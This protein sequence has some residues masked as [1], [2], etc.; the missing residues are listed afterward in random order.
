VAFSR[1][2]G[3]RFSTDA[4]VW[5]RT[6]D[7]LALGLSGETRLF[8][9]EQEDAPHIERVNVPAAVSA[10]AAGGKIDFLGDGMMQAVVSGNARTEDSGWLTDFR[11][12]KT[13]FTKYGAA[14]SLRFHYEEET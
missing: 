5:K 7:G 6:E 8:P 1:S 12:G 4:A 3:A 13:V 11:E 10:D 9:S 14:A 2:V